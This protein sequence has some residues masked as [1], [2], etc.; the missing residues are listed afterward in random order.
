MNTEAAPKQRVVVFIDGFNLY[1]AIA[2]LKP[3]YKL[4]HIDWEFFK[5][6][7]QHLKWLDLRGLA[8]SFVGTGYEELAEVIYFSAFATWLP[9][10]F[11]RH[12]A[13]VNALEMRDIKI[14]LGRFKPRDKKCLATCR[15]KFVAHEEKETDVNLA[16]YLTNYSW[17]NKFDHAI[18]I[19]GDSDLV[20]AVKSSIALFPKKKITIATPP[21]RGANELIAAAHGNRI[22]IKVSQLRNN[23]LPD[24]LTNLTGLTVVRPSKFD[25]VVKDWSHLF[26]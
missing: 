4:S 5:Q 20:P 26:S 23:L 22:R 18:L 21:N 10:Q 9:D 17:Q 13:Y 11:N 3:P 24:K 6:W 1:H 15:E 16:L 12:Q 8:S 19:S 2:N 14:V 25:P 7:R